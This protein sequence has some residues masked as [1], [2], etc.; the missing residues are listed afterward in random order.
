[1]T[2]GVSSSASPA[3]QRER[4]TQCQARM[5]PASVLPVAGLDGP[6]GRPRAA[7]PKPP[8]SPRRMERSTVW[9]WSTWLSFSPVSFGTA[10]HTAGSRNR[11]SRGSSDPRLPTFGRNRTHA[12]FLSTSDR[13]PHSALARGRSYGGVVL[14][15]TTSLRGGERQCGNTAPFAKRY[16]ISRE[17]LGDRAP[18]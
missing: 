8:S 1:M 9:R 4:P 7:S 18:P 13:R 5:L 14:G 2:S 12:R 3:A 6:Q 15:V 11:L 10:S 16:R 17:T